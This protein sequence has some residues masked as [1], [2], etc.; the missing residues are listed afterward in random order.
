MVWISCYI[1]V[2]L[3][4]CRLGFDLSAMAEDLYGEAIV[5]VVGPNTIYSAPYP[6]KVASIISLMR[7]LSKPRHRIS[8]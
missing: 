6:I 3:F 2:N 8:S 4:D 1:P 7:A 5:D